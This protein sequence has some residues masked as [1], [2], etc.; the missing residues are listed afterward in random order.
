MK[1]YFYLEESP[2]MKTYQSIYL[3][4]GNFPFEGKIYGSF[5]LMPARLLGLTYAQYLRFCR[6]VLGATLV[7]KNSKYPVAYSSY[8]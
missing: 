2:Y 1:K 3:N 4:H 7:G 5:N 6:D 8:S